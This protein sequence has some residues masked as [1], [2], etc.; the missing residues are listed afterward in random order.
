MKSRSSHKNQVPWYI[1]IFCRNFSTASVSALPLVQENDYFLKEELYYDRLLWF[2]FTDGKGLVNFWFIQSG[3]ATLRLDFYGNW[4][5]QFYWA[6]YIVWT[7]L[8]PL[9]RSQNMVR[10]SRRGWFDFLPSWFTA[11]TS[12][13]LI[14]C[15]DDYLSGY[16][17]SCLTAHSLVIELVF[18]ICMFRWWCYVS[19]CYARLT[20][21]LGSVR[22]C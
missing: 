3:D 12:D 13:S 4:L 17:A 19:L 5:L 22:L 16:T 14:N 7:F 6:Y 18:N 21:M 15:Q 9:S 10:Q 20:S 2:Y 1:L 8:S 11:Q